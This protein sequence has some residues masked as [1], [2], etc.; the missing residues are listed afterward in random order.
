MEDLLPLA[1]QVVKLPTWYSTVTVS[2]MDHGKEG[3]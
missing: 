1:S 3:K 2:G